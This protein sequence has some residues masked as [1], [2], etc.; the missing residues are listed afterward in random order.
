MSKR[1]FENS[2][3]IFFYSGKIREIVSLF[4]TMSMG[5]FENSANFEVFAWQCRRTQNY[6]QLSCDCVIIFNLAATASVVI[7]KHIPYQ[8]NASKFSLKNDFWIASCQTNASKFSLKNNFRIASCSFGLRC[9]LEWGFLDSHNFISG[10][11]F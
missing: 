9:F 5:L 3:M 2:L 6:F 7:L 11:A 4:V 10:D 8:T 1:L